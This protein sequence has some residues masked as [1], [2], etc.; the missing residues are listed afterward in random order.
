MSKRGFTPVHNIIDNV[1]TKAIMTY[2]EREKIK[3]Q[4][5]TPYD[6]RVNAAERAIQNFKNHT[7]SGLCICDE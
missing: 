4:V 6:H 5:V 3:V 1:E 2:L 7:I